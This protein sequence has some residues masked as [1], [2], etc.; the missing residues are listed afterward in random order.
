MLLQ[1]GHTHAVQTVI[2][3]II[4][5]AAKNVLL[6]HDINRKMYKACKWKCVHICYVF[7]AACVDL[8]F[9]SHLTAM[10]K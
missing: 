3:I 4:K 5:S 9:W 10:C 8:P 7:R 6:W 1:H 2:I